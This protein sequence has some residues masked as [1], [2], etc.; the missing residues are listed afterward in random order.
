ML[1]LSGGLKHRITAKGRKD[2]KD[3]QRMW[4][5]AVIMGSVQPKKIRLEL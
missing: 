2:G 4:S 5:D 1:S 3:I